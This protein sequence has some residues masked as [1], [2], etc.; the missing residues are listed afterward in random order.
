MERKVSDPLKQVISLDSEKCVNCHRCIAVCPSKFCNDG[1]KD[2]VTINHELCIGCGAC[3][4]ACA[5]DARR[6]IDDFQAFMDDLKKG[7]KIVAIVAPAAAANFK[8]QDLELNGWLK[9]IGV[10]AVFDVSFGAELT[11]KS[12]VEYLKKH[13]PELVISQP[14]PALVSYI[15]LYKPDLLKYLSPADSPMAHTFALIKHFY[16]EYKGY[17]MAAISPC[18]AK[19]REFDENGLG[20]YNVSMRSISEYFENNKL[21]LSDFPKTAYENPPAERAVLYSTPGGLMRTALRFV[22]GIAE[23]TRKIEGQPVMTNYF[24]ELSQTLK[25]GKK[26]KYKLIDCLNCE[27]GCNCGAGTVNQQMPLDELET[28]IEDRME[29]R[30]KELKTSSLLGLKKLEKVINKYWKED[31]YTRTYVDRSDAVKKFIKIPNQEE[32]NEIYAVMGKRKKSDFLNCGACGYSSCEEMATAIYNGINKYENCHHF[33]INE[34]VRIHEE[35]LTEK[36][37][38]TIQEVTDESVA[39]LNQ[40]KNH[41]GSLS[42]VTDQMTN[43]VN[44]S[45]TA[46][47]EMIANIKSINTA[48]ESNAQ[49]VQNLENA[50]LSG[51]ENINDVKE[52][53]A[54]IEQN[55]KGL[56]EMS[57]MI[58]Q[59]ASQTN[60]LAMNAAIEAAHAGEFGAGF[61]VVADEIR[62]LAESSNRETKKISE[63][64]NQIKALIDSA[65]S[66]T[67]STTNEF[68]NIVELT[69]MVRNQDLEVKNAVAEENEGSKLVLESLNNLKEAGQIVTKATESLKEGTDKVIEAILDLKK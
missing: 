63:V 9:S 48:L 30:K 24:N 38:E 14:C 31:L 5:H 37:N 50:T 68:E 57:N 56:S 51:K 52:I 17:K 36:I 62:N 39:Q 33:L 47:E 8:G 40:T 3:I 22:P 15:E 42:T 6:G 58:Q 49:T 25:E 11:T 67:I 55:S 59:I 65:Y 61:A 35:R 34:N 21:K 46:I 12:Y 7:E 16:P 13:N 28:F 43:A 23:N 45:S 64:L 19:R 60:L 1:S 27:R 53:V 29:K 26:I 4:A 2:Y 54:Q 69:T 20:D 10:K 66:K 44:E 32:L 41:V 18:Y